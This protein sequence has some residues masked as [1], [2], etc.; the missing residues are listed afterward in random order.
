[1]LN[2]WRVLNNLPVTTAKSVRSE[3]LLA[4]NGVG[5]TTLGLSL[6][7]IKTGL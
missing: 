7:I 1:M 3:N 2:T 4:Q 6:C 5:V